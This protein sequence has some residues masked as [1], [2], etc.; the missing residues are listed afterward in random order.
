MIQSKRDLNEYIAQDTL[1]LG[2]KP[3]L[4]DWI[5]HNEKWF[6]YKYIVALRHVEYYINGSGGAG[7]ILYS[8]YGG[9]GTNILDLS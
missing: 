4:K 2:G 1:R 9:I 7:R 8:F 3:K 5:L 6:I